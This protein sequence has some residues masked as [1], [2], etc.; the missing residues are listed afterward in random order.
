MEQPTVL[1]VERDI[2]V[3]QPLAQYLRDCGYQ[4]LEAIDADEARQALSERGGQI[5]V[6][7]I[8]VKGVPSEH[9]FALAN[10]IRS[11]H[12]G[13]K[14]LLGGTIAKVMQL[15]GDLCNEGPDGHL[16]Y[17]TVLDHIRRLLAG[18]EEGST[19]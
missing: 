14:V 10:W 5:A 13:I 8:D 2:L 1:V 17:R 11:G 19:R 6:T 18:R 15:A 12:P 3:R 16:D 9:G 7:L 4:V